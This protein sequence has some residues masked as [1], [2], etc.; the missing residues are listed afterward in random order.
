MFTG[1][2]CEV[3]RDPCFDLPCRNGGYCRSRRGD[4]FCSCSP[5]WEGARCEINTNECESHLCQN[6]GLCRDR[7]AGYSCDCVGGW[8][9]EYCQEPPLLPSLYSGGGNDQ[10]TAQHCS[11]CQNGAECSLST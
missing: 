7:T 2:R 11:L 4:V 10:V 3:R 8:R 6:G 5:G 1:P 9:G